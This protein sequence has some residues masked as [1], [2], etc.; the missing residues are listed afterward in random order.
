MSKITKFNYKSNKRT[1]YKAELLKVQTLLD[2]AYVA[3]DHVNI[4]KYRALRKQYRGEIAQYVLQDIERLNT[5]PEYED[6]GDGIAPLEWYT[7]YLESMYSS[8]IPL[9]TIQ[10]KALE[11]ARG[12]QS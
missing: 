9:S 1:D 4:H 11:L 2:K 7:A 10:T 5:T 12:T 8:G 6:T 3:Y